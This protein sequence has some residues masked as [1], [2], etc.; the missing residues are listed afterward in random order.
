VLL[1][2]GHKLKEYAAEWRH[3]PGGWRH[4]RWCEQPRECRSVLLLL[5]PGWICQYWRPAL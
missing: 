1:G 3:S 5:R 4:N 2:E